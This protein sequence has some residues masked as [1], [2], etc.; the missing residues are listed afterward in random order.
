[1]HQ[2]K[3]IFVF[4]VLAALIS[5]AFAEDGAALDS[6]VVTGSRIEAKL[7][8]TPQRIEVI[9]KQDIERTPV[10][11]FT[12]LLKKNSSVDVIEYPG[13]SSGVGIRGFRPEYSGINKHTL[14]LID[15][16]PAMSTNLSIVNRDQIE[17]VE[18]L[19]GPASA[20]YGS[21]AMGGVINVI[22]RQSRGEIGGFGEL[23]YGSFATKEVKGSVGGA[24]NE[25][26][27]FDYSGS[28][29]DEA[30]D[31]RM[32]NGETRPNTSY[33]Q[34]N[35]A[36]RL[37]ANL[38]ADWRI[39]LNSEVYYGR[40]IATPGDLAKGT[41]AQTNKDMDRTGNDLS[42]T[43]KLGDHRL[44]L[45]AFIGNESNTAYQKTTTTKAD[46]KYLPYHYYDTHVDT[47]GAQAQD[48]WAWSRTATLVYGVDYEKVKQTSRYWN[49][50]GSE[51]APS[52]AN[53]ERE[54]T[55]FYAQNSWYFN[56]DNTTFYVGARND[57]IAVST[58]A[59]PFKT[60]FAISTTD[61][62]HTSP[63][64]GFKHLLG[65]GFRLHGTAGTGFVVPDASY[66]TAN[67]SSKNSS[68]ITTTTLGNPGLKPET[69]VSYDLG[70]EWTGK[71]LFADITV[72]HTD[73]DDKIT[74]VKTKTGAKTVLSNYANAASAVMRGLEWEG[75]WQANRYVGLALSG[76]HYFQRQ[77]QV[78]GVWSDIT[79]VPLNAVRASI[80]ANYGP[81][82][83]RF[84]V[85][86]VGPWKDNNWE[87]DTSQVI[88]YDGF[89]TED[90]WL[91]YR[92]DKKQSLALGIENLSD[93]YYAEKGG[94]PLAGRNGKIS[95]RYD[96]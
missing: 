70:I 63:S 18:V 26:L 44:L 90:F 33:S 73:V 14:L 80:D 24:I 58:L 36:L 65:S 72:Y 68:G 4:T 77:E 3:T 86:Y 5:R 30:D 87:G 71:D 94:Y 51:K 22:T 53:N 32:G 41:S 55:G 56:D 95:Y 52:S 8:E 31:F 43:G 39:N 46:Q 11:N 25:T 12:D 61:Y 96:F 27:D 78:S 89:T 10:Q 34:Q 28:Y 79:N 13:N 7:E 15:G 57:R 81:W 60:D 23:S 74:S 2:K 49:A 54:T 76:T 93:Q 20:L 64:A 16:R 47:S 88:T 6:V 62:N 19:K 48:A 84:G 42:L 38:N 66:L 50:N 59:T 82:S 17:R 75:R 40:D 9:D 29:F 83:A 21:S 37:G 67:S 1:M 85:R 91:R 69:S 35:H 92:I 45:R